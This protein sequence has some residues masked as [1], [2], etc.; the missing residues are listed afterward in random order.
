MGPLSCD[1]PRRERGFF[2]TRFCA[3]KHQ[4]GVHKILAMGKRRGR[5]TACYKPA[6]GDA[7]GLALPQA[8][9]FAG[10]WPS[11]L[12]SEPGI[13]QDCPVRTGEPRHSRKDRPLSARSAASTRPGGGLSTINHQLPSPLPSQCPFHQP[14]QPMPRIPARAVSVSI[15]FSPRQNAPSEIFFKKEIDNWLRSL[16]DALPNAVRLR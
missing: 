8:G 4:W 7:R 15:N 1:A 14:S 5:P 13:R 6:W 2:P 9:L 3:F 10:L 12:L 16:C 11:P